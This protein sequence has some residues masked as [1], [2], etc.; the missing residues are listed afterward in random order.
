[1]YI[2]NNFLHL[3]S[4]CGTHLKVHDR[5]Q[6]CFN[7]LKTLIHNSADILSV[8]ISVTGHVLLTICP[9]IRVV[10]VISLTG[11]VLLT[12][13]PHIRVVV[14]ISVTGHVLLTICPHIRVVGLE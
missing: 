10:V 14:V 12:I 6:A 1:M 11:H 13:C 2:K 5:L 9:H 8:V 4:F 3:G 7:G